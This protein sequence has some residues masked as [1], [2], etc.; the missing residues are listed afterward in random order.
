[1]TITWRKSL[2]AKPSVLKKC[3]NQN[4]SYRD[5]ASDFHDKKI[6]KLGFNYTCLAVVLID[7][8]LKKDKNF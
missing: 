1:M 5:E 8:V 4:K 6:P 3:K 2:I 7:F